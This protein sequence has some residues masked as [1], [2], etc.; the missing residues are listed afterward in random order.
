[1][2][3]QIALG[4]IISTQT[5]LASGF[6]CS[7]LEG[8]ELILTFVSEQGVHVTMKSTATQ[9]SF[10]GSYLPS[11]SQTG[12]LF[13]KSVYALSSAMGEKATLVIAESP[14]YSGGCRGRACN[15]LVAQNQINAVLSMATKS[16]S[17]ACTKNGL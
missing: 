1:M 12:G 9:N 11:S 10:S 13:P 5:A 6:T 7:N 2:L 16:Y 17:Y 4:I 14:T 15:S 3:K 8:G